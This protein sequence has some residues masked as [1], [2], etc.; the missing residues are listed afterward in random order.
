VPGAIFEQTGDHLFQRFGASLAYD[1]RNSNKLPNHGQRT[2][3]DPELSVGDTTYYKLEAKTAWYFPGLFKGHVLEADGRAGLDS[4]LGSGDVPF[5]DREYLGGL[6]SLR[7]FKYRNIAPR[8]PAFGVNQAMPNEPIGGDSFWYGSLEYSIPI[9]E[10]ENGPSVRFALFYDA[11]AVGAGSYSFSGYFDDDA[12]IGLRLD[13][14][15]LGPLRL[16][17]GIP[18]THDQYNGSSGKFQFGVGYTREF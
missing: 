12:G 15:H 7:G 1:T 10:K 4:S 9:L 2:E 6:Y 3:L 17:Y 16:D 14:P 13:I 8:D 18:I 11:G 5:Y